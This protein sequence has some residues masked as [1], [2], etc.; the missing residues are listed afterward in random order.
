MNKPKLCPFC[1]KESL[2]HTSEDPEEPLEISSE[3]EECIVARYSCFVC[4]KVFYVP[5][6]TE[7]A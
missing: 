7:T 2:E 1:G 6:E 4:G 5:L 3:E